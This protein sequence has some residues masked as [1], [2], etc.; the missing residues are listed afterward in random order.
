M[1]RVGRLNSNQILETSANVVEKGT[2]S[3]ANITRFKKGDKRKCFSCGGLFP[4]LVLC[5]FLWFFDGV[6]EEISKTC[7]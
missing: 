4:D 5:V 2:Q 7:G 1:N 6:V 3:T